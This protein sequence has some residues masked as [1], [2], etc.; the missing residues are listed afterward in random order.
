MS[1][2]LKSRA[3][4][5]LDHREQLDEL[6]ARARYEVRLRL[7][8]PVD[9]APDVGAD[10]VADVFTLAHYE[11]SQLLDHRR[12]L[13]LWERLLLA[14]YAKRLYGKA[15]LA[16]VAD[17]P[18]DGGPELP[19]S[20]LANVFR[21]EIAGLVPDSGDTG[22]QYDLQGR[23]LLTVF[24]LAVGRPG[25]V[26]EDRELVRTT[27]ARNVLTC[28]DR[29]LRRTPWHVLWPVYRVRGLRLWKL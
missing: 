3:K 22:A 4:V 7:N 25:S 16:T 15:V 8:E 5:R 12:L 26:W 14:R 17:V 21:A 18:R 9:G 24:R 2:W 11:C 19:G 10:D 1:D 29:F 20:V 6:T 23:G 27:S 13:P 28:S